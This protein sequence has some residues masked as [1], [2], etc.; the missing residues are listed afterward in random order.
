MPGEAHEWYA[1][2]GL[3]FECTSCGA[4]CTGPAGYVT[5]TEDEGRRLA[6][7]LG[8]TIERFHTGYTH[9][10]EMGRSL[11]E[12]ETEH[13]FDCVFLDRTSVPGKAICSVYDARPLQCRTFPWWPENLHSTEA[14]RRLARECE[15]VGRGG[16]VP[17]HQI[18]I[19]RDAQ[20]RRDAGVSR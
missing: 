1:P 18:R 15:G 9:E 20:S 5:F 4:C 2:D 11:R 3:R 10:T 12:I 7:H 17:V 16:F 6:D 19:D 14:W 8:L 13:G